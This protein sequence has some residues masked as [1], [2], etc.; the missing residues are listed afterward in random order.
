MLGC[1]ATLNSSKSNMLGPSW[2]WSSLLNFEQNLKSKHDLEPGIMGETEFE[3]NGGHRSDFT[4]ICKRQ[5]IFRKIVIFLLF[6][7]IT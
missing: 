6:L 1:Y 5:F 2:E 4:T 3:K 7:H